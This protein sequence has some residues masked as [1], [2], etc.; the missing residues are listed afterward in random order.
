MRRI[1]V[2]LY[3]LLSVVSPA[4]PAPNFWR[5]SAL[6]VVQLQGR[7]TVP[8]IVVA[9]LREATD[10]FTPSELRTLLAA[11]LGTPSSGRVQAVGRGQG[12]DP[13]RMHTVLRVIVADGKLE[14]E[15]LEACPSRRGGAGVRTRKVGSAMSR[16]ELLDPILSPMDFAVKRALL[17]PCGVR[18]VV[19][20]GEYQTTA[21]TRIERGDTV[22]SGRGVVV[23]PP[24]DSATAQEVD[25]VVVSPREVT[26]RVGERRSTRDLVS[27]KAFR[28]G[29][30]VPFR[31]YL[32]LQPSMAITEVGPYYEATR[33]GRAEVRVGQVIPGPP[34]RFGKASTT[35]T[36]KVVP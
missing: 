5:D 10:R 24:A 14:T 31:R 34:M 20:A 6:R 19:A 1:A 11:R 32:T 16:L 30:E 22:I 3:L 25:S 17:P 21:A 9:D 27:S 29:V 15:V 36:I 8:L 23:R 26:L 28:G 13:Q 33:E 2:T 12:Y 7:D 4:Q 18:E 35:F